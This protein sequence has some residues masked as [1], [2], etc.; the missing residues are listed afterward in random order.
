MEDLNTM[1][2][3]AVNYFANEQPPLDRSTSLKAEQLLKPECCNDD[4]RTEKD[5]KHD[6]N[7]I[8]VLIAEKSQLTTELNKFR[9]LCREK[10]LELEELRVQHANAARRVDDLTQHVTDFQK[11]QEQQ[12]L[13]N[14]E[15]QHKLAQARAQQ[16]DHSS[17]INELKQQMS[18]RDERLKELEADLKDKCNELE[19]SQLRIRQLSDENSISKDNRV[20]S[21]T[22]TQF[23]YEQQIRDLQAMVQQ[24]SL[25]KEQAN[26]QYQTYVQQLN[27]QLQKLNDRNNELADEVTKLQEREKQCVDHI[28][29]LEKEIQKNISRQAEN[30]QE[31]EKVSATKFLF[32]L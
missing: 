8:Q 19:L 16:E 17:H 4:S 23:M 20:E 15:L 18:V 30:R 5:D 29:Q 14:A 26:T 24:L 13:H 32:Q 25:D 7:A 10:D 12:K 22:Q 21:L 2:L 9:T 1:P 3:E 6:I 28:Q 11:H 31:M 27:V